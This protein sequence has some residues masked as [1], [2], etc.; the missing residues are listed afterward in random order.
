MSIHLIRLGIALALMGSGCAHPPRE[1]ASVPRQYRLELDQYWLLNPPDGREFD[2]SG[3][4]LT[5]SGELYC[6]N[7]KQPGLF[8]IRFGPNPSE[9]EIVQVADRFTA[10]QLS[11]PNLVKPGRYDFEGLAQ[12]DHGRMYVCEET[13]RWILRYN[14]GRNTVEQL[15][16]D[17]SPVISQFSSEPNASW[18]GIAV[19]QDKLYLANERA[20]GMIIVVNLN[21]LAIEDHYLVHP[22]NVHSGDEHYSD[23]CWFDGSLFVLLRERG[24]ILQV[25]PDR[26]AVVA[27]FEC[28]PITKT[29]ATAY[30]FWRFFHTTGL[31]GLAV[32]RDHFWLVVDNNGLPRKADSHDFRPTLYR[33]RRPDRTDK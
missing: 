17:W 16:I 6:V 7:D 8:K 5:A 13:D 23:L 30:R 22:A 19:G 29:A 12:D 25:D 33:C 11:P 4:L 2:A 26:H 14:P 24:L 15:R 32:S 20:R 27:E 21:T 10:S 18:E 9:A 28:K 3:L 1:H 31:E